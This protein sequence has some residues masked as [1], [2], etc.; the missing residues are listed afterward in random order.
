M[1]LVK[2]TEC[3]REIS[4]KAE[5]CPNCGNPVERRVICD[6]CG[7]SI[8]E[9][10]LECPNCGNPLKDIAFENINKGQIYNSAN[11]CL[12]QTSNSFVTCFAI[13]SY[14]CIAFTCIESLK[15]YYI[16]DFYKPSFKI[17]MLVTS[18]LLSFLEVILFVVW[19]YRISKNMRI[20]NSSYEYKDYWAW[21]AWFIPVI[22]LFKPYQIMYSIWEKSGLLNKSTRMSQILQIWWASH[23][24]IYI[25]S[26][27]QLYVFFTYGENDAL[28]AAFISS[29]A[30]VL[31]YFMDIYVMRL[32]QE[33]EKSLL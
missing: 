3:G 24:A 4:D 29:M 12:S 13:L 27:W 20:L 14:I 28:I 10:Y 16:D 26:Y 9:T 30:T 2:C 23:V 17:L 7:E 25:M 15:T 1:A 22:H 8:P 33:K 5:K 6:E 18:S 11:V 19:M 21:L 32:Y 31:S